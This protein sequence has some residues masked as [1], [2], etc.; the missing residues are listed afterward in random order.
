MFCHLEESDY[1]VI[2]KEIRHPDIL[3]SDLVDT[4]RFDC[5]YGGFPPAPTTDEFMSFASKK[6]RTII[7][8][9]LE[10]EVKPTDEELCNPVRK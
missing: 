3:K 7:L 1:R 6:I 10:T 2:V 4:N 9:K 8:L 5:R